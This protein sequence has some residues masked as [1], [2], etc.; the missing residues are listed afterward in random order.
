MIL[1]CQSVHLYRELSRARERRSLLPCHPHVTAR[2][3]SSLLEAL[4]ATR[5]QGRSIATTRQPCSRIPQQRTPAQYTANMPPKKA[6][7]AAKAK[8]VAKNSTRSNSTAAPATFVS[9]GKE[10]DTT[11]AA[12]RAR[13]ATTQTSS[14]P[15]EATAK[16]ELTCRN[17]ICQCT[18]SSLICAHRDR[19]YSY[20]YK[21]ARQSCS[22]RR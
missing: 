10:Y 19:K 18:C 12:T 22:R 9:H 21:E 16:S 5:H 4:H 14:T 1:F 17:A 8:A 11:A 13:R 2:K 3:L 7:T 15:V 6:K 20:T